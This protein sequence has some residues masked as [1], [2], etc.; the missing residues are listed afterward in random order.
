MLQYKGESALLD[1]QKFIP[2]SLTFFCQNGVE[3]D[4]IIFVTLR[5]VH[6]MGIEP[7][8]TSADHTS[9]YPR[10]LVKAPAL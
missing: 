4:C 9:R 10:P 6:T 1:A 2:H 7:F 8:R 5:I 3:N